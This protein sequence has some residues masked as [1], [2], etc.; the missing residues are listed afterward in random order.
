M[1]GAQVFDRVLLDVPCSGSG[2][3]A[4]RADLRWRREPADLAEMTSLQVTFRCCMALVGSQHR[5]S[6]SP[7]M[8]ARVWPHDQGGQSAEHTN[9]EHTLEACVW[10]SFG[11]CMQAELLD[12][13]AP[14]VR[15][16]GGVLVYSTCS[17]EPE[18][19]QQQARIFT[20]LTM[21]HYLGR[22]LAVVCR[23]SGSKNPVKSLH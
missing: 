22:L 8:L 4:K 23:A 14:L 19:N 20:P 15:R 2:V 21:P 11:P 9:S 18:E 7:H 13:A 10:D 12:A 1:P 6:G 17:I 16:G 5:P 3:L